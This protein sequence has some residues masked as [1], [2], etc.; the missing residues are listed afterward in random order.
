MKKIKLSESKRLII[1]GA[2]DKSDKSKCCN[3]EIK[4]SRVYPRGLYCQKCHK[5]ILFEND[6]NWLNKKPSYQKA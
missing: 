2:T 3:E 1:I 5:D 6:V 4:Q